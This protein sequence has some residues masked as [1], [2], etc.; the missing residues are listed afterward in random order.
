M[1]QNK[2]ISPAVSIRELDQSFLSQGARGIGACA[3]GRSPKGP[4]FYPYFVQGFDEFSTVFGAPEPG[5]EAVYASKNYLKNSTAL[6]F[7]R[8]LGH[9]DGTATNNGYTVNVSGI[10]DTGS[11]GQVLAILHH[12]GTA[13]SGVTATQVTGDANNFILRINDGTTTFLSVTASFISSSANYI[14]KVANTDP[15]LFT[16]YGHYLYAVHKYAK[17][18]SDMTASIFACSGGLNDFRKDFTGG[19]TPWVTS[20]AVGGTNFYNLFRFYTLSDGRATNDEI[21]VLISDVKPSATPTSTPYGSFN[22]IVRDFYDTD[23]RP[24]ILETFTN[25]NLDVDSPNYILAR[26]GNSY[27]AFDTA[28][29]KFVRYGT[30]DRKSNYIRCELDTTQNV[31][32]EAL[33]WG[34]RG[35]DK[36]AFVSGASVPAF[37]FIGNQIDGNGNIDTNICFGIPFLSGGIA[38]RMRTFPKNA[39]NGLTASDGDFS[40]SY[41]TGTWDSNGKQ[42]WKY[43]SALVSSQWHQP[44][45]ASSSFYKFNLP[46]FGGFDG[47]D[48]RTADPLYLA[49][50]ADETNIGVVSL[51]RAL[52]CVADPDFLDMNVLALPGIHNLK[53]TDYARQVVNDRADCFYVMD[54]TGSTV[55][56]VRDN[57]KAR[58]LDDN[59]TGCYYPRLLLKDRANRRNM[60]VYPSVGVMGALAFSDRVGQPWFA[61]AGL[62]RGGLEQ[63]DIIDVADRLTYK[64]RNDLYENRI[65]PIAKF[66]NN[67]ISIWGQ[68]TLQ[69]KSSALDRINVRRLMIDAKKTVSTAAKFLLFEQNTAASRERLVNLVQPI[70]ENYRRQS[71]VDQFKIVIDESVNTADVIDRNAM[72]GKVFIRPVKS[73]EFISLDFILTSSG[74]AFGE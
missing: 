17:P 55:A 58:E 7:V 3:A 64:D 27:E 38:D 43:S 28:T 35:F 67:G 37:S 53:V 62:N 65:N 29:R 50:G 54:I 12:T 60:F 71:G 51:K 1:A 5:L 9:A 19:V 39:V 31:P 15:T 70:F 61:V 47:W 40:L 20:Q 46:F 36:L 4:A 21:K 11:N 56:E 48:L 63:F 69:I 34:H 44:V 23:Q 66:P 32:A 45:F 49:N 42:V 13:G 72:V 73:T 41:L 74:V 24:S 16:T 14:E 57:L 68:K 26:I 8:V 25:V 10:V 6:N 30:Y 18:R 59:Y 2:F 33:P 52:D 22:I